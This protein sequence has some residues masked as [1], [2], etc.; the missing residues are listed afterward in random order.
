MLILGISAFYHTAAACL[1]RDGQLVAAVAEERFTRVKFDPRL[2]VHSIG[3][4]LEQAGIDIHQLDAIAYY[5]QPLPKLERQLSM[6]PLLFDI[7]AFDPKR[8][9][10]LIR[11]RL[12]YDGPLLTFP[13][14]LSHA[15]S[16]YYFSGFAEAAILTV[17]GV[18]EWDTTSLGCAKDGDIHLSSTVR[19]PHSLGL[20]YAAITQFLGFAVN[21]D[22]YKVMGLAPYGKPS[23]ETKLRQLLHKTPGDPQYQLDQTHFDFSGNGPLCKASLSAYLGLAARS[24]ESSIDAIHCDLAK[25]I[26][27]VLESCMLALTHD[28]HQMH[29]SAN[30]CMAGGV[31]LNCVSNGRIHREGPFQNLFVQ[32]AAG[33]DGAC[34]GAAALGHRQLSGTWQTQKLPHAYWGPQYT[35]AAVQRRLQQLQWQHT[36]VEDEDALIAQVAQRLAAGDVIGWFHGRAEFGPRALGARS[37]L[38]NPMLPDIRDRLNAKVKKRE[39]FRP[40][41]PSVLS[42]AVD[43][44]FAGARNPFMLETCAVTS[45]LDLPGV[46]HVDDS[47][48]PQVVDHT[49]L[50]RF[51]KLIQAFAELTGCPLVVNTSFNIR[52]EP[53]VTTPDDALRCLAHSGIDLLVLEHALIERSSIPPHLERLLPYAKRHAISGLHQRGSGIRHDIYTFV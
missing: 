12:G 49:A 44:H 28:L 5:E 38:A 8:P 19:F 39:S 11:D 10:H 46:R 37:I 21:A 24:P 16:A 6:Q 18:G 3:Y 33:D 2:P 26:Q 22:E 52:G 27:A 29:P 7:E 13:H 51:R 20:F 36:W 40:F 43:D 23:Y 9:E 47:A 42:E 1:L 32:P 15:A 53:I 41:A 48:R 50:P 14:H 31:A 17:D 4:C 45:A 30:L 35:A 25:S 34:L